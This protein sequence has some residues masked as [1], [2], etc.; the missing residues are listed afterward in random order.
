MCIR[1]SW[2]SD[3]VISQIKPQKS[4]PFTLGPVA[5]YVLAREN[6]IKCVRM[7]LSGKQ[8]GLPEQVIRERLGEM[9]V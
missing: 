1:D 7:I 5:A 4:N 2:C 8:N 6:E 3:L 9:Y